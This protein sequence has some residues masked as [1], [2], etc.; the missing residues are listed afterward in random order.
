MAV[1]LWAGLCI[2]PPSILLVDVRKLWCDGD[3]N[4]LACDGDRGLGVRGDGGGWY[5][6]V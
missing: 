4:N 3:V 1:E 6:L 2:Y 5:E